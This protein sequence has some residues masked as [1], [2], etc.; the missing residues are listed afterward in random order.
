MTVNLDKVRFR[1][2]D[3]DGNLISTY[4]GQIPAGK[5][6][7]GLNMTADRN[8]E[9]PIS[10]RFTDTGDTNYMHFLEDWSDF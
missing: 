4:Y 3:K 7:A 2:W 10:G 9:I 6:V 5:W 1:L 8:R